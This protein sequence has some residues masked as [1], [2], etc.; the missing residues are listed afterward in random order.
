MPK[1]FLAR[2]T[3]SLPKAAPT[4]TLAS[5]LPSRMIGVMPKIASASRPGSTPTMDLPVLIASTTVERRAK[6]FAQSVTIIL[7]K[8]L[9]DRRHGGDKG[10]NRQRG[11]AFIVDGGDHAVILQLELLIERE[12]RQRALLGDREGSKDAAGGGYGQR[13]G[14]DQP[15]GDR[16]NLE[17]ETY[18]SSRGEAP[19]GIS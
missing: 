4:S 2:S 12:L 13:N 5:V 1:R 18:G 8:G 14:E 15:N 9:G 7:R 11:A 19:S 6:Q 16:A 10:R 3:N 17:H